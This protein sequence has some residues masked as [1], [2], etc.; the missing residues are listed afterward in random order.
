MIKNKRKCQN[1]SNSIDHKHINAKFCGS[2]CKDKY[3][4]KH[5]PRGYGIK[6]LKEKDCDDMN[7]PTIDDL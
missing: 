3:H 7:Y 6:V 4:N 2:K 1:C 5:N